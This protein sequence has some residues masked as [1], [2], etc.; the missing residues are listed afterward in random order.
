MT[1]D[2]SMAGA[3]PG[4][5]S[6]AVHVLR[7]EASRLPPLD[8]IDFGCYFD[9]FA[10][11]KL[12]LLGESTHGTSEFYRARAAISSRLIERHGFDIIAVE[13]DWPTPLLSTASS[14][15]ATAAQSTERRSPGD[16]GFNA[17]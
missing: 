3:N 16:R 6:E 12:V 5:E 10:D 17:E 8:A 1:D 4:G 14:G 7:E 2:A 13:A 11:A 9:R 15:I